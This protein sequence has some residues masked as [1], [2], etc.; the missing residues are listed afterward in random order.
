MKNNKKSKD[1]SDSR[2]EKYKRIIVSKS[3]IIS[4][5]KLIEELE[6]KQKRI[7]NYLSNLLLNKEINILKS[8]KLKL[9]NLNSKL[10]RSISN[11]TQGLSKRLTETD[12]YEVI[13]TPTQFWSRAITWSLMS[14]TVLG[15]TWLA[16]AKTE[17]IIVATGKL[18]P[19]SGVVE[20]QM[21]VQGVTEK[22]YVKEGEKVEKGQT[23]V[24]LDT[25]ASK[26]EN[27][28][29]RKSIKY[30]QEIASRLK[31]LVDEGAV[32]ELQ[33]LEQKNRIE[34]L[35][36]KLIQSEVVLRYQ[37]IL[38]PSSGIV[39]D[40]KPWGPGFVAQTS[41]PILKIVPNDNLIAKIEIAS[42]HIGFVSV[43]KNTSISIDSYPQNDFGVIEGFVT[44]ISS[45][46]LPPNPA[47][48]KGYRFPAQVELEAQNLILKN[49][50]KLPLQAGMSLT[51]NIKLRK[52]SYLQLLLNT[53]QSKADS[54]RTL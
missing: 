42:R 28:Q 35:Q 12:D 31:V 47:V 38:A 46:A 37:K 11:S 24:L 26:S 10:K 54:L 25:T 15:V 14:G 33:F 29:L 7:K 23:L 41:Q 2:F 19:I 53:F 6:I 34:Q 32:S 20:V 51:A 43:G 4:F 13:L 40:L 44:K 48:N 1:K 27:D 18:E 3:K 50:N 22:I 8:S 36:S 9:N 21:P 52:V 49:G 16:T 30:N 39:F 5:R 17:E 45:D